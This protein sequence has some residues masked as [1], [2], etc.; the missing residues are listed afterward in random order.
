M[1]TRNLSRRCILKLSSTTA[2]GLALGG[3]AAILEPRPA[4]AATRSWTLEVTSDNNPNPRQEKFFY[5]GKSPGPLIEG[6]AGDALEVK[7]VNS[8]TRLDDDCTSNVNLPHGQHTT[9]L[10]THGLHVSPDKDTS[11]NIDADNVF[12]KVVPKGQRDDTC[13][14]DATFRDGENE[15]VF[16]LPDDHPPG[17]HWYH[18]HKHGS[19]ERQVVGGLAGPLIVRDPDGWMPDYIASAPERIIMISDGKAIEVDPAGGGQS[20]HTVELA[21]GAVERWRIINADARANTF[22]KINVDS[23]DIELYQIAYDGLT[24]EERVQIDIDDDKDPWEAPAALSPGNRTD[25]MI[26]VLDAA[27]AGPAALTA[28]RIPEK[29]LHVDHDADLA[30]SSDPIGVNIRIS[31]A[32]ITAEWS[33]DPK[34]PGP[35][36]PPLEGAISE[37]REVEFDIVVPPPPPRFTINGAVYGEAPAKPF[38]MKLDTTEEWVLVNKTVDGV[39]PFHIHV[40]PF[41]VTHINGVELSSLPE[42]DPRRRLRRWQD[43]IAIPPAKEDGTAG[44]ITMRTHFADFAGKFVIHCHILGHEDRGMM[45]IV[46]VVD[47]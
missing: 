13:W 10:H 4:R 33:D 29:F 19:T 9:N 27:P 23:P 30:L 20:D 12:L 24:L 8:M 38:K 7:V 3:S 18:A 40:N 44:T 36:L 35:G 25:L 45:Q 28:Q 34:L 14:N 42:N 2:I 37:T 47:Q 41:F 5:N 6:H 43:T 21:P 31:S 17:T 32:P 15:F 46:E 39:H 1:T 16:E 22:V 26:R 11:G